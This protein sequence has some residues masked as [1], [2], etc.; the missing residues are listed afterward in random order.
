MPA[1]II[2]GLIT[3]VAAQLHAE[4]WDGEV[5]RTD[6][7]GNPISPSA[8]VNSPSTWPVIKLYMK[9]AGFHRSWNQDD[10]FTDE[11]SILIQVWGTTRA[12]SE[13]LMN[14]IEA[15]FALETNWALIELGGD[16]SNPNYVIQMLLTDWCSVQEEQLRTEQSQLLYRADMHYNCMVHG[17][18]QTTQNG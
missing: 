4:V 14:R 2:N 16:V 15:L 6:P 3:F 18:I 10:P 1:P 11:G 8:P 17:I 5:P 9:D 7:Q 12:S 13:A